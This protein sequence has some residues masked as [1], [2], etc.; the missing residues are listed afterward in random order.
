MQRTKSEDDVSNNCDVTESS[1]DVTRIMSHG[2]TS[3][4]KVTFH[5]STKDVYDVTNSS[6]SESDS[7]YEKWDATSV[8]LEKNN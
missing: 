1:Y 4:K 5:R 7:D 6:S 3:S 8:R 2:G